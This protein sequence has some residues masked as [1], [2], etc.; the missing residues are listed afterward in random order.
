MSIKI[1][2]SIKETPLARSRALYDAKNDQTEEEDVLGTQYFIA[3]AYTFASE[4]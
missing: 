2:F 3:K 4:F 1:F